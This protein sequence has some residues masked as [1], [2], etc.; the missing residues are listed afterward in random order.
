MVVSI[1]NSWSCRY[2]SHYIIK[3][4]DF[5]LIYYN[6]NLDIVSSFM[7]FSNLYIGF[8]DIL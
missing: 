4:V 5:M 6:I 7:A 1:L 2:S 3:F 8:I